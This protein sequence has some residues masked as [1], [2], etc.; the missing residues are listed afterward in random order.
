MAGSEQDGV[1][2]LRA[3]A[4]ARMY[5]TSGRGLEAVVHKLVHSGLGTMS[6]VLEPALVKMEDGELAVS[7]VRSVLDAQTDPHVRSYLSSLITS[8]K[9]GVQR[10][11]ELAEA[12]HTERAAKAEMYGARLTGI[13]NMTAAIFVF[14]F[15]PTCARVFANVPENPVLPTLPLPVWFE[16]VFYMVLAGALTLAL[17]LAR[18][19]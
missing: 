7:A 8:G 15:V 11:D 3:I 5:A 16:S 10:L 17:A 6:K 2:L 9:G 14:A 13:V 18:M 1:E 12:I 19:K 4:H